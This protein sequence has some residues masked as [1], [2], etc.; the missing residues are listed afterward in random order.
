MEQ[1][2]YKFVSNDKVQFCIPL[3]GRLKLIDAEAMVSPDGDRCVVYDNYVFHC[4][5]CGKMRLI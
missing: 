4:N 5:R 1:V 2:S 3:E